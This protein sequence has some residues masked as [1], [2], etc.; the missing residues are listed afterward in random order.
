MLRKGDEPIPGYRLSHFMGRGAFGEVWRASAPGGTSAALKFIDL[1]GNGQW[2]AGDLWAKLGTRDDK[3][4]G[5]DWDGDGKDDIGIYGPAWPRD[6]IA[7]KADPGLPDPLNAITGKK[8]NPPPEATIE[9][10][11]DHIDHIRAIA[12]VDHIGIGADFYTSGAGMAPKLS[13]VTTYPLLF[14][15]LLRRGYSDDDV[16]KIA[17]R[18]HLR[19]MRAM[20]AV[21]ERLR[22]ERPASFRAD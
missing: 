8:K 10:V 13:N 11:A 5:G 21:S 15:E 22:K 17:G 1:N 18:N 14:A 9:E 3:P 7:V 12:G 6:P 2:D 20:E 4:V 19:A 16:L